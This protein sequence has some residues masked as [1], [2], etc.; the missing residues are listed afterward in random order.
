[1][2][3]KKTFKAIMDTISKEHLCKFD[4][5]DL[6]FFCKK[7][8]INISKCKTK[9]QIVK[10]IYDSYDYY[11]ESDESEDEYDDESDEDYYSGSDEYYES[12]DE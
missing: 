12:D 6:K 3:T 9:K 4:T 5:D 8:K 2:A 7:E 10:C 11:S 1:M